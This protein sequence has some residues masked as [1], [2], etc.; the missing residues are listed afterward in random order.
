MD[1]DIYEIMVFVLEAII[2]NC[3]NC[4]VLACI[5]FNCQVSLCDWC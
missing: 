1:N 4:F 3:C 5:C 2:S